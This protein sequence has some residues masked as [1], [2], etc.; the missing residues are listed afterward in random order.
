M[1]KQIN[2]PNEVAQKQVVHIQSLIQENNRLNI[3]LPENTENKRL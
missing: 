2:Q 1:D 3:K